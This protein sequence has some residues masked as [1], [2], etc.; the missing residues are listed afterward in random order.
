VYGVRWALQHGTRFSDVGPLARL[1]L[2][3]QNQAT[4]VLGPVARQSVAGGLVFSMGLGFLTF[5]PVTRLTVASWNRAIMVLGPA[6]QQSLLVVAG[7][8]RAITVLGPAAQ[9]GGWCMVS[10]S[11]FPVV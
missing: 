9:V 6:A 2:T 3:G 1:S 7:P 5:G 11:F 10:I 4:T 8:I